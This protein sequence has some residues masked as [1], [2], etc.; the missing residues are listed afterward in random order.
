MPGG[1]GTGDGGEPARQ[2]INVKPLPEFQH[3]RIFFVF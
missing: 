2:K 3:R 1:G